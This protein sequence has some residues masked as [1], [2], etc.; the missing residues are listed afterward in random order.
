MFASV[1]LGDRLSIVSRDFLE[2]ARVE[3]GYAPQ[4][5]IK[6]QDCYRQI[7]KA[8]GDLAVSRFSKNDLFRLRLYMVEKQHSPSRQ[9]SLLV[10][11][12]RLLVFMQDERG[13][14]LV[15]DPETIRMPRRPRREVLFLSEGEVARLVNSIRLTTHRG[16]PHLAN[17]R[18]RALVEVLLGTAMRIGEALSLDRTQID[19]VK[20][21]ARIIGKGNKERTVFFTERSIYWLS[22]YLA[23]R[24]DHVP[25][26]FVSLNGNV[27]MKRPDIW[28]HF[29]RLQK[30]SGI[31]KP[32]RPHILRHTAAT[33]LLLNGCPVGHIK[34]ILGHE[35]LETTC[36]YYL[37]LDKSAAK[38]AHKQCLHY[39]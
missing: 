22:Q 30:L 16:K 36:R 15:M 14:S 17:L 13:A 1:A 39:A 35:R 24:N 21:E 11:I 34:E 23:V 37:G 10:A 7:E 38:E 12:K 28:R 5:I 8:V 6:Y 19:N 20:R 31:V 32:I 25:A 18:L 2:F 33:Q 9:T 4:S 29:K 27:R 3:L 26:A